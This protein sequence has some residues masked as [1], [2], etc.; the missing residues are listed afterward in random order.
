MTKLTTKTLLSIVVPALD[1]ATT[2]PLL[3]TDLR[4]LRVSHEIIVVDGG[5]TDTTAR[6]AAECGARV[7]LAPS[8]RGFQL[9]AGASA[10]T[11]ELLWFLHADVRVGPDVLRAVERIA[12]SGERGAFAFRLA[13][14]S[15]GA[16]YRLLERL[17]NLRS[18]RLSLP[19]GDQSLLVARADYDSAGGFPPIP[20][21]EDVA[22]VR[23]LRRIT[24][25]SMLDSAVRV[26][27]RRW[28]RDGVF[29]STVRNSLLLA[30]Y[31][32]G[33]P[34][35]WIAAL[36]RPHSSNASPDKTAS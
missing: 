5:S 36:Y 30:A 13:I 18:R 22:L 9:R 8:G 17:A 26:S 1:E 11:A 31:M 29:R 2:I 28:Q 20:I 6:I 27:S 33:A 4:D 12:E 34:P 35:G 3:L 24:S 19:Y 14:D 16:S 7:V 15:P 23:A 21:M 32:L 25:V 10:A